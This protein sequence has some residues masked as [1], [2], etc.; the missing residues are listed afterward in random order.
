VRDQRSRSLDGVVLDLSFDQQV[1]VAGD[2]ADELIYTLGTLDSTVVTKMIESLHVQNFKGFKNLKV[3]NLSNVNILV[4]DNGSGK[5]ALLESLFLTGGLGPE[6]YLRTRAWRGSGDKFM[7]QFDRD[8]Y[9]AIWKELF[10]SL[11][12]NKAVTTSFVD[13]VSGKRELRIY[14]EVA[15]TRLMP[16]DLKIRTSYESGDVHPISFE[17]KT[18]DGNVQ[19]VSVEVTPQGVIQLPQITSIYPMMFLST[20]R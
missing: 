17:W 6:I 10:Y 8:Q 16:L 4:G 20:P 1:V 2:C 13:S 12:Q 7:L 14:Y 18:R 19:K 15:Q 9:E 3:N 11:D 5:T